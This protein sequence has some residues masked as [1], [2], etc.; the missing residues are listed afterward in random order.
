MATDGPP[1]AKAAAGSIAAA[2]AAATAAPRATDL[3]AGT[4]SSGFI[5]FSSAAA[6]DTS[7]MSWSPSRLG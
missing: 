7:T 4:L 5:P 2:A 3:D 6:L 1:P